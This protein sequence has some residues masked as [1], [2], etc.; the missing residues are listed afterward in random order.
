MAC[1]QAEYNEYAQSNGFRLHKCTTTS[2]VNMSCAFG[3]DKTERV[4]KSWKPT[5]DPLQTP[6]TK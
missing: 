2:Y 6:E 1:L 4:A 3:K 5:K